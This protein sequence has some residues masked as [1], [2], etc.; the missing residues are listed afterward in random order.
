MS[1]VARYASEVR[2]VHLDLSPPVWDYCCLSDPLPEVSER[3]VVIQGTFTETLVPRS[4]TPTFCERVFGCCSSRPA[5]LPFNAKVIETFE[6]YLEL[7]YSRT[8]AA[9]IGPLLAG[10]NF[11]AMKK[12]QLSLRVKHIQLVMEA[13]KEWNYYYEGLRSALHHWRYSSAQKAAVMTDAS[14][15]VQQM[16]ILVQGVGK[17]HAHKFCNE[18]LE[19]SLARLTVFNKNKEKVTIQ[20][21]TL[22]AIVIEVK[23]YMQAN[24]LGANTILIKVSEIVSGAALVLLRYG[25]TIMPPAMQKNMDP[26]SEAVA[27]LVSLPFSAL[28]A[29]DQLYFLQA[30]KG[31]KVNAPVHVPS[32]TI[33]AIDTKRDIEPQIL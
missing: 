11:G 24:S 2:G 31:Q 1:V 16:E 5:A 27:R 13:V 21:I 26:K 19:K 32:P 14:L 17:A 20:A 22:K 12:N 7:L 25:Y 30:Y 10:V 18:K 33:S 15:A 29:Q 23:S 6:T 3:E 9:E 28:P 4:Y 8:N